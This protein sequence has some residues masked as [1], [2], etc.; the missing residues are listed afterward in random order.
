MNPYSTDGPPFYL[1]AGGTQEVDQYVAKVRYEAGQRLK[2][3]V[4]RGSNM[5]SMDR[6]YDEL[7]AALQFPLYFGRNWNALDE[8]L[9]DLEWLLS[10]SYLLVVA[11]A[12][13]LL[14]AADEGD[15]EAFWKLLSRCST[16]WSEGASLGGGLT[17][18]PT[19]FHVVLQA[20]D[21]EAETFS[22]KVEEATGTKVSR[23]S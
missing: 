9:V 21:P 1:L 19:P 2:V 3:I 23:L 18:K 4:L 22:N 7:A 12:P 11:D 15:A 17:R 8:C 6:F 10:D 14:K 13:A 5:Q 16:E 20:S